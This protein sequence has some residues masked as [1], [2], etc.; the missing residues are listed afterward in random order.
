MSDS[1]FE[2]NMGINRSGVLKRSKLIPIVILVATTLWFIASWV[3]SYIQSYTLQHETIS[4]LPQL[5]TEGKGVILLADIEGKYHFRIFNHAGKREYNQSE[6]E[7]VAQ[8]KK[9][10]KAGDKV[11][12]TDLE[13]LTKR[14]RE[15]KWADWQDKLDSKEY[16][17][18]EDDLSKQVEEITGH[19]KIELPDSKNLLL[20]GMTYAVQVISQ[21][22]IEE[23]PQFLSFVAT[24]LKFLTTLLALSLIPGIA[25]MIYR[26]AFGHWFVSGLFVLFITNWIFDYSG[27]GSIEAVLKTEMGWRYSFYFAL[28]ALIALLL[29]KF[30]VERDVAIESNNQSKWIVIVS[31][32]ALI[33][34]A[35]LW[36]YFV[37]QGPSIFENNMRDIFHLDYSQI[38]D[39][40]AQFAIVL[41]LLL[42]AY[43]M[44][45]SIWELSEPGQSTR[46]NIVV[47]LDGTWNHPGQTD[48]G[49]LAQ[50]NVFKL[51][52]MLAGEKPKRHRYN[53]NQYKEY[54]VADPDYSGARS[55]KQK[56][57]I[58]Q[59]ALYYHGVGNRVENSS[60]G[61]VFGGAFGMGADAIVERA[62]L[63][64]VRSYRKGDRIFI[65]GFSRGAAIARLLAGTINKRGI[66]NY[67]WTIRI[68]GRHCP[69]W[70]SS[71]SL[72]KIDVEVLGCWDTVGAFGIAKNIIGIP[73]QRINLLKDLTIPECVNRAYHM[74]ALDETRDAFVPTL[75]DKDPLQENRIVEV[76]FS[77]NHANVGGGYATDKLS[78]ISLDFLLK[79]VSSGYSADCKSDREKDGAWG[80]FLNPPTQQGPNDSHSTQDSCY[81]PNP[82]ASGK[83]RFS[84]GPMYDHAAREMPNDA[85]VHDSVFERMLDEK[86]DYTP[87]SL[88][89]LLDTL[90]DKRISTIEEVH[91]LEKSA[92]LNKDEA[93]NMRS[94]AEQKTHIAR[95]SGC[96]LNSTLKPQKELS[97]Q[98]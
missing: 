16:E 27:L 60:L 47:C 18:L 82:N 26:R 25:G 55:K 44:L 72:E 13:L 39:Y 12:I 36:V 77:G 65:Y 21:S 94:Q 83:I 14:L 31:A 32:V 19:P 81:E 62:Y 51:F 53:A 66:P 4:S 61:Q 95:W 59:R 78:D 88:F 76:W 79:K 10:K 30:R 3:E 85:I 89:N 49:H 11:K 80:M 8:F 91:N 46:R 9:S 98:E 74:V 17:D 22:I 24:Q 41:I 40:V 7:I 87:Q 68:F 90:N 86:S 92:N 43:R 42:M 1:S 71:Q 64:L 52:R 58:L 29:F 34:C 75:M 15:I 45:R 63:D 48:Y 56:A 70:K 67:I 6:D 57:N 5:K 50:T 37:Y 97:N 20:F 35:P 54:T 28:M 33:L 93:E 2:E 23:V 38:W 73:F 96:D 69:I 84:T